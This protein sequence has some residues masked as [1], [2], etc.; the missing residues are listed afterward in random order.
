MQRNL[1][2][3]NLLGNVFINLGGIHIRIKWPR[4]LSNLAALKEKPDSRKCD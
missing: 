3:E 4:A 2:T 1:A